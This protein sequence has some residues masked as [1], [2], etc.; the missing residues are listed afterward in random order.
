MATVNKR[1]DDGFGFQHWPLIHGVVVMAALAISDSTRMGWLGHIGL[2]LATLGV[3]ANLFVIFANR[4]RMPAN[5]DTIPPEMQG[6]YEIMDNQTKLAFLG[7]WISFRDWLISPGDLCLWIG[8]AIV[9]F[10]RLGRE[11]LG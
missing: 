3:C 11:L 6:K 7:D 10:D 8:L 9:L 1:Q 5:E 2:A 4:G